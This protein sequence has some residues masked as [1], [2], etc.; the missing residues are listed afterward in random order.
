MQ[1][2]PRRR[3][4]ALTVA[5]LAALLLGGCADGSGETAGNPPATGSTR[6]PGDTST[7]VPE[8]AAGDGDAPAAEGGGAT[9]SVDS[10]ELARMQRLLDGAESVADDADADSAS[11]G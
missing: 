7:A 1:P 8:E 4:A 11:D 2:L 6:A 3:T 5:A 10:E 9:Q